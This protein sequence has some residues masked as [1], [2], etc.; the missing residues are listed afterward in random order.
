MEQE[1]L[2]RALVDAKDAHIAD[3]RQTIGLQI[4]LSNRLLNALIPT[5]TPAPS[6]DK[7]KP[8]D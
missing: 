2:V 6:A 5:P 4:T 3:L 8:N 1:E 7:G